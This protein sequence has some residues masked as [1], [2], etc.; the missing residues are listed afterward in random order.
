MTTSPT[1]LG[2]MV[3]SVEPAELYEIAGISGPPRASALAT[4]PKGKPGT[5]MNELM[6]M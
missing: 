5:K 2:P 1:L 4:L 6:S 3:W